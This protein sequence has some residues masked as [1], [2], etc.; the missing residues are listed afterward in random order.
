MA[1]ALNRHIE[2]G[3]IIVIKKELFKPEY[4]GLK[5]RLLIVEDGFGTES[6]TSGRWIFGYFLSDKE[7]SGCDGYDI[8]VEET[9]EYQ[10]THP[11]NKS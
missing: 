6:F 1:N 4:Q 8:D 9:E 2:K 7:P 3:E 5:H 11:V 10:R